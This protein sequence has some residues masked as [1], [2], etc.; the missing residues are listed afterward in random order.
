MYILLLLLKN[1]IEQF[2]VKWTLDFTPFL[3][4]QKFF[5][6]IHLCPSNGIQIWSPSVIQRLFGNYRGTLGKLFLE[7]FN[8][9]KRIYGV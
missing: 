3:D 2:S 4:D 6:S 7:N 9:F 8:I 5:S 1:Y